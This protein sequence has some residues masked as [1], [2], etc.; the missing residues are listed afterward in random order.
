MRSEY[1]P[2]T[3]P[4][5]LTGGESSSSVGWDKKTSLAAE[6]MACISLFLRHT[7]FVSLPLYPAS[8]RRMIMSSISNVRGPVSPLSRPDLPLDSRPDELPSREEDDGRTEEMAAARPV[9]G[10]G[11]GLAR[12]VC[13]VG[14]SGLAEEAV[15]VA[16]L[17]VFALVDV[18]ATPLLMEDE[19]G[20]LLMF[21][22][23]DETEPVWRGAR[24]APDE[25]VDEDTAAD[26]PGATAAPP[27]CAL[28]SARCSTVSSLLASSG[29]VELEGCL[30]G[31][32]N[33]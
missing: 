11:S 12:I 17:F 19:E 33:L 18:P 32:G 30:D 6:Q 8:K 24:P 25:D 22:E 15:E 23:T 20:T 4:T 1:C 2:C 9:E 7:D 31:E 14:M 21:E 28:P 13:V 27:G 26:G 29:L 10:W 5:I 3:S 16:L